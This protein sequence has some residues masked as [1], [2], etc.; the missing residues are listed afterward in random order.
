M[1]GSE[2]FGSE[3]HP[4]QR[5]NVAVDVLHHVPY[6]SLLVV[7]VNRSVIIGIASVGV[8]TFICE[9]LHTLGTVGEVAEN[10]HTHVVLLGSRI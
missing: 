9:I 1:T 3:E 5:M 8:G 4:C 6:G 7:D 2:E 10:L